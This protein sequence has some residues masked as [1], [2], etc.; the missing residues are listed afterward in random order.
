MK[1]KG[2][3]LIVLVAILVAL[4]TLKGLQTKDESENYTPPVS[5]SES[6]VRIEQAKQQGQPAWLL[7]HSTS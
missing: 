1:V 6:A 3:I 4:F 7:F 5:Q 2:V